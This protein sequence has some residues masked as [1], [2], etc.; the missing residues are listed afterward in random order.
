MKLNFQKKPEGYD[1]REI[2]RD[3]QLVVADVYY[4]TRAGDDVEIVESHTI[5]FPI[6]GGGGKVPQCF[7]ADIG[8]QWPDEL[9]NIND[10]YPTFAGWVQNQSTN[11]DWWK[12]DPNY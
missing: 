10:R 12:S 11:S 1:F 9:Q 2:V 5:N 7:M 6:E 3:I 8:T 4:S